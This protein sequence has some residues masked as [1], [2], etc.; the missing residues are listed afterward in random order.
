VLNPGDITRKR[1]DPRKLPSR[2]KDWTISSGKSEDFVFPAFRLF[3][4]G[5]VTVFSGVGE[6]TS[7]NLYW[8][9]NEAIWEVGD[10]VT[11][12]DDT[13]KTQAQYTVAP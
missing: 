6:N 5:S 1:S 10:V 12:S 13:G 11:L 9:L 8:K 2:W 7:I 3:T 4:G